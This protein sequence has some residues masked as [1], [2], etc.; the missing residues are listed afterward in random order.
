MEI[1]GE[2]FSEKLRSCFFIVTILTV[3]ICNGNA[4]APRQGHQNSEN[5]RS[6]SGHDTRSVRSLPG[7]MNLQTLKNASLMMCSEAMALPYARMVQLNDEH[8]QAILQDMG[9]NYVKDYMATT[10][11]EA[12]ENFPNMLV[13]T[14][15]V[16]VDG[17]SS[18]MTMLDNL[19]AKQ[20]IIDDLNKLTAYLRGNISMAY[21]NE[22]ELP[23]TNTLEYLPKVTL[24]TKSTSVSES[25]NESKI[26][27]SVLMRTTNTIATTKLPVKTNVPVS[28]KSPMT[29]TPTNSF[30][31]TATK[32]SY[33]GTNTSNIYTISGE[34]KVT[35][36]DSGRV[37]SIL[38]NTGTPEAFRTTEEL[39]S[40]TIT[41]EST[42]DTST[43]T[44]ALS[45]TASERLSTARAGRTTLD[46][47]IL[48]GLEQL[49]QYVQGSASGTKRDLEMVWRN[50]NTTLH[51]S[52]LLDLATGSGRSK[53]NADGSKSR[54]EYCRDKGALTEDRKFVHLCTICAAT[55][56]L[57]DDMF[58]RYINEAVCKT[59]DT[60]C[61]TI[62]G[63]SHGQCKQTKFSLN[64]L[65][66]KT[67][68]CQML[69]HEG[70]MLVFENWELVP[71]M[72]R[73][74]CECTINKVSMFSQYAAHN[75]PLD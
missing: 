57:P 17:S 9:G 66:K 71:Q 20:T 37:S 7:T 62:A 18:S 19:V 65:R 64:M 50:A 36:A 67:G 40:T 2:I 43:P 63:T 16:T 26:N 22:T 15:P 4:F 73:V 39:K 53:R 6:A 1:Q 59:G 47:E 13:L 30:M 12:L 10:Q 28:A 27:S 58:P 46:P 60:D 41:P 3:F 56:Q 21:K 31:P 44:P 69:L 45:T 23:K 5:K 35:T 24:S 75:V 8:M 38:V 52:T 54:V 34:T 14:R 42:Q 11:E 51:P 49:K 74:S 61:F 29:S 68:Y 25:I 32:A 72:I 70:E 55:T 48:K 33:S